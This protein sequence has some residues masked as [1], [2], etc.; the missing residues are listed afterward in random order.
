MSMI[1]KKTLRDDHHGRCYVHNVLCMKAYTFFNRHRRTHLN[2]YGHIQTHTQTQEG[3]WG[4]RKTEGKKE[5]QAERER[6]TVIAYRT[7]TVDRRAEGKL[8]A[9]IRGKQGQKDRARET[10]LAG[11][12]TG[13]ERS[14]ES[15]A[16]KERKVSTLLSYSQRER[17]HPNST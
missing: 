13:R 4:R 16:E 11:R 3:G 9:G 5:T 14:Q 17:K 2:I 12:C 6:N 10:N 1:Q 15:N 8:Q 7:T